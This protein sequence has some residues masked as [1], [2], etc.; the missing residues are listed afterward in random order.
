MLLLSI[1]HYFNLILN[2]INVYTSVSSGIRAK[3]YRNVRQR[4][5]SSTNEGRW[6]SLLK[7][8]YSY[9]NSPATSGRVN[10]LQNTVM[11]AACEA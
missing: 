3:I 10:A 7:N 1:I 5:P 11:I 4:S 2:L 8:V 6:A 9:C